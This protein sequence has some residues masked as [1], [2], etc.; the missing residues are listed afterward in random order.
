MLGNDLLKRREETQLRETTKDS[1]VEK[2]QQ[3][4]GNEKMALK[5]GKEE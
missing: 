4:E 2:N 5:S 1:K 3:I